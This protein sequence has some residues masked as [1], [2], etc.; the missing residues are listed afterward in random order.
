M[1][2]GKGIPIQLSSFSNTTLLPPSILPTT[3]SAVQEYKNLGGSLAHSSPFGVYTYEDI[4]SD[5]LQGGDLLEV[6]ITLFISLTERLN[7]HFYLLI[8]IICYS[9]N[10]S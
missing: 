6:A 5:I 4:F 2:V 9:L 7:Q 3:E 10:H 8:I 1:F